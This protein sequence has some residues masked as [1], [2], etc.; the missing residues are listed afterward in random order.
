MNGDNHPLVWSKPDLP[1]AAYGYYGET[2][3]MYCKVYQSYCGPDTWWMFMRSDSMN[4]GYDLPMLMEGVTTVDE[5]K[6][7]AQV[8]YFLN[9]S[10]PFDAVAAKQ[11]RY[12]EENDNGLL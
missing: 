11:K 8:Y 3:S 7:V 1:D 2:V 5:A 4:Q 10:E 6:A 9:G 12:E